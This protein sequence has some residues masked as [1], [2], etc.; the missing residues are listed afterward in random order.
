MTSTAADVLRRAL[1]LLGPNGEMWIQGNFL[2]VDA[3][4]CALG[5]IWKAAFRSDPEGL[6]E[7][8]GRR[9]LR[10]ALNVINVADWNDAPGRTFAEV[11][12][13]FEKAIT[14]A[15]QGEAQ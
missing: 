4:C 12:A 1:E 15:E 3:E 2:G 7:E 13:A 8:S 14:L 6:M 10:K 9:Y 11:K 5:A